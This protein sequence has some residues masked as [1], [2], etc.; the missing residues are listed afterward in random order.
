MK[1]YQDWLAVGENQQNQIDFIR[2]LINEHKSS[3]LYRI[4]RDAV[5]YDKRQNTTI[6][7]YR[8]WLYDAS[9]K[10]IPDNYS[11]N[12]K[13][14]SGFFPRFVTQLNQYLLGNGV[15]FD[16]DGIKEKLGANFDV[17][18]QRLGRAALVQHVAFG[19][20]N[21]DHL[22][23]F[24]FLEFAPLY[25]ES[26]GQLRGGVRFWQLSADKPMRVIF[27]EEDGYTSYIETDEKNLVVEKEKAAYIK[28]A[29]V[30]KSGEVIAQEGMNYN[31]FPIIPLYANPHK[32]SELVGIREAIDCY[33]LIK[34]GF[35][36]DVDEATMVYWLIT[37]AGGMDAKDL[38][39]F[40]RQLKQQHAATVDGDAGVSVNPYTAEAPYQ[41]RQ[42]YLETLKNDMYE[43]FQI[44]NVNQLSSGNKTATEIRAAYEPMNNKA[45]QYEYC[46]L[47][48]LHALFEIVGI[49]A[50][51]TFT[52]SM[53]VNENEE[54][55][56]VLSAAQYLDDETVL[57]K[58]KW[59]T[60]ED[61]EG[62]LERKA[63][64][65][66]NRFTAPEDEE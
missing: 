22:D 62:I 1:T 3:E 32:Q 48:F 40:M 14:P 27:F 64:D 30:E 16:K 10:A 8:K 58:L 31:G 33:D 42:A 54:T 24:E 23:I 41:A 36:N 18:L 59:L 25:D 39:D 66:I 20:W 45:D 65:D 44:I 19:F 7:N 63:D 55:Q 12:Y 38:A 49:E 26:T 60:P 6:M 52:R 51:P 13:L 2:A 21:L 53:I 50:N 56:M 43:D 4:A 9:G 35:A 29:V 61:V 37:N 57:R 5:D 34:S 11:A 17:Q 28:R 15:N 46:V 47:T